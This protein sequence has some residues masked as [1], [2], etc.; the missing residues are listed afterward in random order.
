VSDDFLGPWVVIPAYQAEFTID[1][2][3]SRVPVRLRAH[4]LVVDDG[5][6][7]C[8]AEIA[9]RRNVEVLRNAVN[10]GYART[11]KRGI[12]HALSGGATEVAILHADGQYPPEA[13][14]ELLGLLSRGEADLVMGSRV[15]DGGAMRR[16]MPGYKW[17]ANRLLTRIENQCY[18]LSLSEYHTGMMAY[19]RRALELLP[20]EAVSDTFHFDGEMA[21][22]AGRRGLR[23]REVPIAHVYAGEHTHLKVVPYGL[24]VLAIAGAV[25]L[26]LY[27][28]WLERR[29]SNHRGEGG[30]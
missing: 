8:T 18:G 24:T 30:A 16:G 13:L 10:R 26:G 17:V 21:M 15:M 20:F 12:R 9:R 3:L 5:S 7:D 6:V 14:P 4:I 23:I 27:D 22:L 1:R 25:R 28:A 19:S 29:A 2:V 11:Q